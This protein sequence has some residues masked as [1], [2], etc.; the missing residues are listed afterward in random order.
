MDIKVKDNECWGTVYV[1]LFKID[2]IDSVRV[3]TTI[4]KAQKF[5]MTINGYK[6]MFAETL[7]RN[8]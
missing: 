8:E 4:D 7:D 5:C 1:V 6:T 2:G 3:F